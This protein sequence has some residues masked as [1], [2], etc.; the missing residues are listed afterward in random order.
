MRRVFIATLLA[1]SMLWSA[2]AAHAMDAGPLERHLR[3]LHQSIRKLS[4]QSFT[5]YYK[6]GQVSERFIVDALGYQYELYDEHGNKILQWARKKDG[7]VNYEAWY[8]PRRTKERMLEDDRNISYTSFYKSGKKWE[9]YIYNKSKMVK[10]YY[11]YDRNG[12]LVQ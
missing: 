11:V 9:Q 3:A 4:S 6:P 5:R 7:Q 10:A 8:A 2:R 12:K 1:L